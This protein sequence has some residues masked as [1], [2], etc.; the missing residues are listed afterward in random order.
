MYNNIVLDSSIIQKLQCSKVLDIATGKGGLL[1][2]LLEQIKSINC[3]VGYDIAKEDLEV[4]KNHMNDVRAIFIK[5]TA[6]DL[7][8][9]DNEF[10]LVTIANSLHHF[11]NI[12]GVINESSRVIKDR[13]YI[14]LI[15]GVLDNLDEAQS[16]HMELAN[17]LV[18]IDK[19]LGKYHN[20]VMSIKSIEELV[21]SSGLYIREQF[22]YKENEKKVIP[23]QT[24]KITKI[25]NMIDQ[26][27][28]GISELDEYE[29]LHEEAIKLKHKI[30]KT[31][32]RPVNQLVLVCQKRN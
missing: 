12:K 9:L 23:S 20:Y 18:T 13:G 16:S 7:P 28:E 27:L 5:G 2:V 4:A 31:G 11:D 3:A 8:F 26:R 25:H 22:V 10:D 21:E 32:L 14:L 29:K 15:E 6:E 24:E 19:L 30:S 1:K 17:F